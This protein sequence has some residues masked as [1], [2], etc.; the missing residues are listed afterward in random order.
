LISLVA[1]DMTVSTA[2]DE[3]RLFFFTGGRRIGGMETHLIRL[4][5]NLQPPFRC[6][7]CCMDACPEY[8]TR[9]TEAGIEHCNLNCPTLVRPRTIRA[10]LQFDRAVERFQPQIVH[11]YGFPG[12]IFTA[13]LRAR[14]SQVR[15]ITS[16]RSEDHNRRH[17]GIRRLVNR[18]SDKIVCVSSETARFVQATESPPPNLLEVIS[19]GV[20][21]NP[22]GSRARVRHP[23]Q[24]VR[25]GTLGTVKPI[26][27]TDLLVDAFMRFDANERVEL[28]IAGLIDRPWAEALR[29]RTKADTR[30]R[31][32]G[33]SSNPGPFLS[34]LDVFVLP[35]RSEGMSNALLEAMATGLPCIATDVGSNRSLLNPPGEPATGLV[36]DANAESLFRAMCVMASDA[37]ARRRYGGH[38]AALVERTYSISRMVHQYESLYRSMVG[39]P[40]VHAGA[41][42]APCDT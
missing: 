9:L 38:G 13:L 41:A 28:V 8:R 33:R 27:G 12:D 2:G 3:I 11:A 17:Q 16:R 39:R 6:F 1:V 24:P 42:Q 10:Y 30:I 25:F 14:G 35:S 36:C 4:A 26:K 32:V 15:I 22:D 19:N 23:D 21:L 5:S 18:F 29:A 34:D 37:E 40:L 20:A 31:F 7:V